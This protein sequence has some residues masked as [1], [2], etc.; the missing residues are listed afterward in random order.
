MTTKE[1]GAT[2]LS[3]ALLVTGSVA[4]LLVALA[5]FEALQLS[6]AFPFAIT[7]A[8]SLLV[9]I[10]LLFTGWI[11]FTRQWGRMSGW[12]RLAHRYPAVEP[13]TGQRVVVRQ[14]YFRLR[15]RRV[16]L[17]AGDS[18]LHFR[19]HSLFRLPPFS[20]AIGHLPFSVPWADISA[21]SDPHW[22]V[23]EQVRF[24]F[25]GEPEVPL[26]VRGADAR[27]IIDASRG[28]VHLPAEAT[29]AGMRARA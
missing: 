24:N 9:S 17:K 11:L 1:V 16:L 15:Y 29:A 21:E 20:V 22:F 28:R 4:M 2:V 18:H 8:T 5:V 12:H 14:P 3:V 27:R 13:R 6:W 19:L 7:N 10:S 25:A 26:K 23:K